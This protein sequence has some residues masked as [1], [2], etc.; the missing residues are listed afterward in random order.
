M[1]RYLIVSTFLIFAG[2]A[3]LQ[4]RE[5]YP[6][7]SDAVHSRLGAAPVWHS[8]GQADA[9]VDHRIHLLLA[10]ELTSE[11][12]VQIALLQ[13]RKVQAMYEQLGIA[14]A[15]LVEAGLLSNPIFSALVQFPEAGGDPKLTFSVTQNFIELLTIPMRKRIA[16]SEYEAAKSRVSDEILKLAGEVKHSYIQLVAAK[17]MLEL[18]RSVVSAT[19]SGAEM[20]KRLRQA[21]NITEL[22]LA[23]ELASHGQAQLDLRSAEAEVAMR[24]ETLNSLLGLWEPNE[25][26]R[27]PSQLPPIPTSETDFSGADNLALRQR[28]D[29]QAARNEINTLRTTL[30]IQKS[31]GPFDETDL[32]LESERETDRKWIAG[33][34]VSVPIPIFNTGAAKR[35]AIESRLRA[36]E[37]DYH[38]MAVQIRSDVRTARA[39]L[40]NA[41]QRLEFIQSTLLPLRQQIT[42]QTQLQFNAMNAGIFQLLQSRRDEI[43]AGKEWIDA[44]RDYWL[45]RATLEQ[46]VG[47]VM[48]RVDS[49]QTPPVATPATQA[50]DHVHNH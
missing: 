9:E 29:L 22:A 28:L 10:E 45:A 8:N 18:R 1:L 7:V 40:L 24:Q 47:G 16:R 48:T 41:R 43:E 17:Q 2:C 42:Q 11:S 19:D 23:S 20:A 27:V 50:I 5:A 35:A 36:A 14:Q 37:A 39:Q 6:E 3:S 21:G 15:E 26:I 13:N 34:G 32:T 46:S 33:P 31:V 38:A 12:A 49:S 25:S 30:G 44:L 4:P